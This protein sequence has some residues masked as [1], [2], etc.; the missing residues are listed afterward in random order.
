M[1]S[2]F[3]ITYGDGIKT[4]NEFT[5]TITK[6]KEL[7]DVDISTWQFADCFI[8]ECNAYEIYLVPDLVPD[9]SLVGAVLLKIDF[10]GS[11]GLS[12]T[13]H[14]SSQNKISLSNDIDISK[15][16]DY[17]ATIRIDVWGTNPL[18]KT[19]NNTKGARLFYS[20]EYISSV[21]AY[22]KNM[23]TVITTDAKFTSIVA[24][25]SSEKINGNMTLI[26]KGK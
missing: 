6:E 11:G 15:I 12:K 2:K 16:E 13:F 8:P 24:R 5:K 14:H 26:I 3:L 7:S 21:G 4:A 23:G 9:S 17:N 20:N 10:F 22:E 19:A 18:S 1:I 25:Y